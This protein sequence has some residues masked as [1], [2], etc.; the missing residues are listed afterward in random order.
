M[1]D[2]S[3]RL[4]EGR[5]YR[6][7]SNARANGAE[8]A[9]PKPGNI[10]TVTDPVLDEDGDVTVRRNRYDSTLWVLPEYLEDC[11]QDNL[12]AAP[13]PRP[14]ELAANGYSMYL[15]VIVTVGGIDVT[16]H[17]DPAKIGALFS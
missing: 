8:I 14:A 15:P 7:L 5:K 17:L 10:V 11:G 12:P 2:N 1:P 16:S 6:V 4:I 3:A 13:E 9:V